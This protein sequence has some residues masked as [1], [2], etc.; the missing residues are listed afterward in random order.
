MGI[1]S[2]GKSSNLYWLGRYMERV[3]TT[4][5]CFIPAYDKMIECPESY[6]GFC[7]DLNI[8][9]FYLD[10]NDFITRYLFDKTNPDSLRSNFDRAYNNAVVLRDEI[11]STTLSYVQMALDVLRHGRETDAHILMM[12]KISDYIFAFWGSVEDYVNDSES[13]NLLRVGK[14]LERVDMYIRLDFD[15]D[16]IK[17]QFDKFV[18]RLGKISVPYNAESL[19]KLNWFMSNAAVLKENKAEAVTLLEDIFANNL[20]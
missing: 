16:E 20:M 13:R 10:A 9:D 17:V 8:P 11:S 18:Y 2:I 3:G 1:I 14:Y 5:R 7:H 12:Q 15:F 4:I 19:A 6:R